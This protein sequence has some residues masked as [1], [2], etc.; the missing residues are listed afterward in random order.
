MPWPGILLVLLIILI[1]VLTY[2]YLSIFKI[3]TLDKVLYNFREMRFQAT[4][5]LTDNLMNNSGT[6]EENIEVYNFI[7]LTTNTVDNFDKLKSN[8]LKFKS[9]VNIFTSIDRS[10]KTIEDAD[11][12]TSIKTHKFKKEFIKNLYLAF[13][14][15]P[16]FRSRILVFL[17]SCIVRLLVTVGLAKV[18]G[19]IGK[20]KHMV[21]IY[22]SI[23]KENGANP[24]PGRIFV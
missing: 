22:S 8:L 21:H 17:V 3:Y 6:K 20:L 1:S 15:V 24:R 9:F 14:T 18:F 5:F 16:F 23:K 7:V 2:Q 11:L 4:I 13:S 19:G 10:F 12:E